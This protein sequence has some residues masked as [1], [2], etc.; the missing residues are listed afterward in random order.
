LTGIP[1]LR[2]KHGSWFFAISSVTVPHHFDAAPNPGRKSDAA[3]APTSI[4]ASCLYTVVKN[5]KIYTGT[6]T[7][8]AAPAQVSAMKMM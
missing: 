4:T 3:A 7:V 1:D 8:D 2:R 6:S 5:S